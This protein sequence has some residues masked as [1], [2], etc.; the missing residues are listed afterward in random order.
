LGLLPLSFYRPQIAQLIVSTI[1]YSFLF[2]ESK[3]FFVFFPC[4]CLGVFDCFV[5]QRLNLISVGTHGSMV[6]CLLGTVT[7]PKQV[8][9]SVFHDDVIGDAQLVPWFGL[10]DTVHLCL[11]FL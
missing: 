4:R 2:D 9:C 8:I 5:D 3:L 6:S 11:G 10:S 1:A 7:P